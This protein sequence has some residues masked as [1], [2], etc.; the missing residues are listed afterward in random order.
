MTR[1]GFRFVLRNASGFLTASRL[2]FRGERGVLKGNSVERNCIRID[3]DT[4]VEGI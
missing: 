4:M 3:R 1:K 2:A